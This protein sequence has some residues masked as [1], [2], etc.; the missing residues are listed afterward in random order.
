[1]FI[2]WGCRQ[3]DIFIAIMDL[4][5]TKITPMYSQ[6]IAEKKNYPDAI[7]F[8]RM[9]DFYE[10]FG[11]DAK[12]A[13][14]IL[15]IALTA[16]NKNEE[17][18][19]PMCGIPYH[20]Y[21]PYLKKLV[22]AGY[23]VAICEQ[24]EDPSTAKGIVKRGVVRVVT[25]GTVIEEDVLSGSDYNIIF[26]VEQFGK[27]YFFAIA[28]SSTG[29]LFLSKSVSL[30]DNVE[31]WKPKE[32]ISSTVES[33]SSG[34]VV[35]ISCKY[36]DEYLAQRV[37]SYFGVSSLNGLGIN[38]IG[39]IKAVFNLIKYFDDNFLSVILKKPV[40][41]SSE[42]ELYLD[43]IAI[44]TLEIVES[45][46]PISKNSLFDLLNCCKTP[47][48]ERLLKSRLI[49]PL[50]DK[51]EIYRR[52][53]WIQFFVDN[54]ETIS[55]LESLLS[56]VYDMERIIT[57][58]V[59]GRGSPRDLIWLKNS[60]SNLSDIKS[61]LSRYHHQ[62]VKDFIEEF[63]T[64]RDLWELIDKSISDDPPLTTTEGGIIKTGFSPEVDELTNIKKNSEQLLLKIESDEKQKTG[65]TTLKV[66]Y[67][68]VFGYYIEISRG[69]AG[70]VPDY[71]DRK[72]TLVNAER[73]TTPELKILENKIL[74]AEEELGRLEYKLFTEIRGKMA[75]ESDRVRKTSSDIAELDFFISMAKISLK[76]R[77]VRPEVGDFDEIEIIDGRHPVIESKLNMNFIPNDFFIGQPAQKLLVITG[78]NMSGKSTYLRTIALI[79]IMAHVG[80][81]IPAS[82][83]RIGFVDRI[84]TRVGA[85]DNLAKG[86]STFMVEMLE[87]A[88]ILK[89]ATQKS[90]LILDEV[91]RGTSTFDGLSIA[92][93]VAEYIAEKIGSKTLFATH[94]HE[95][96]E[97]ESMVKGV[98]NFTAQ[99][100]EWKNEIIFMKKVVEG[101]ADKSYGIYVGKLAGLPEEML[102]RAEEVL[103]ILEKH[104]ISIDGSLFMTKKK[105]S[106]ERTVVQPMLVFSDHPI[107]DELKNI[108]PDD[109]SPKE[110]LEILYKLKGKLDD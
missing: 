84:F 71:Y 44:K 31:K 85:S 35:K 69:Q 1:M 55:E 39:F 80:L 89:N 104:E 100:K 57:R 47:M 11:E 45:S 22:D 64:L 2:L 61:V 102:S 101:V 53:E 77:Y 99:V 81:F 86:E 6:F 105:K 103:S 108:N 24:L 15:N 52:Q 14:K 19:I 109:L 28:D 76:Y 62:Y 51:N 43:S 26:S 95:L 32:I 20:S 98:K 60:I 50:R 75:D 49:S 38:E 83:G 10:M 5:Q 54:N 65:I 16:R 110:A 23:K 4:N 13:S 74:N 70:K 72:Q 36:S 92:W 29:D 59:A 46:D 94:Y 3:F 78:P 27:H 34:S 58:I 67:N 56:E 107:I 90:L 93:A 96:T 25:P 7:L 42:R 48:G 17:N 41:I 106:Y 40:T 87:T 12:I 79:T 18:P 73:F 68:K 97:L 82:K 37:A 33:V 66:R 9:G 88:N 21:L 30:S 91:G 63:D 8:F